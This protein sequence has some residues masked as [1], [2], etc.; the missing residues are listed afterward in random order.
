MI[1]LAGAG[2]ADGSKPNPTAYATSGCDHDN[3]R[4]DTII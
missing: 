2:M 3:A 4:D 1:M